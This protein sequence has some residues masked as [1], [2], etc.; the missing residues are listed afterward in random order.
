VIFGRARLATAPMANL[1]LA[2]ECAE[3]LRQRRNNRIIYP[4]AFSVPRPYIDIDNVKYSPLHTMPDDDGRN[5]GHVYDQRRTRFALFD[6]DARAYALSA[7]PHLWV[8]GADSR[9]ALSKV[10]APVIPVMEYPD[11]TFHNDSTPLIYDLEARHTERSV[12]PPDPAHAFI[13]HLIE[14]FADEWVT[15]AMFRLSL[16][17]GGRPDPD[18]PLARF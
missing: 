5:D 11:G 16:A 18:E 14:D 12:I 8:H 9:D 1:S 10:K 2:F 6:E 7:H 17:G 15:K 13:A 4:H 3:Q